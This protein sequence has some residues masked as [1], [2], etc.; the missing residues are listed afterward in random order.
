[1]YVYVRNEGSG[2]LTIESKRDQGTTWESVA[3]ISGGTINLFGPDEE[4]NTNEILRQRL[5]LDLDGFNFLF[6]TTGTTEL[7]E[8]QK[9]A[10]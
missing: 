5:P 8:P 3:G 9:T 6:R 2:T 10:L 4:G 7:P 1:M